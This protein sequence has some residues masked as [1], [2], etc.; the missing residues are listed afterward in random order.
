M[1]IVLNVIRIDDLNA[2]TAIFHRHCKIGVMRYFPFYSHRYFGGRWAPYPQLS[3]GELENF[4]TEV[5]DRGF[6]V[7]LGITP[8][9][10]KNE[11]EFIPFHENLPHIYEFIIKNLKKNNML[12]IGTHG[13]SHAVTEG[14]R[15]KKYYLYNTKIYHREFWPWVPYEVQFKKI[16]LGAAYMKRYFGNIEL[17]IPPGNVFTSTTCKIL[18]NFSY[19]RISCLKPLWPIN[20]HGLEHEKIPLQNAIH[21]RDIVLRRVQFENFIK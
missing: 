12:E 8:F 17:F 7:Q 14:N 5:F 1:A 20:Y 3:V 16:E 4:L 9:F 21:D 11:H 10:A 19:K 13:F 18:R 15:Y 2:C 6:K